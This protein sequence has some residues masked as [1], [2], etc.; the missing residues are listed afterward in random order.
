M[1]IA[2]RNFLTTLRRYKISSLL[3]VAGL[4]L[5][6]TAFYVIMTQVWWEMSYNRSLTDVERIYLVENEDWY[7]PGMWSSWLNRPIPERVVASTAGVEAGGCM[8]GGF[9]SGICWTRNEAS[10]GYNKFSASDGSVSLPLLDVFAFRSVA[11]DVHDLRKPKSVIVSRSAAERNPS[12]TKRW[13]SWPCSRILPAIR[14]WGSAR[15]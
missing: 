6:F 3:N 4:T 2:F 7:E 13:R 14:C 11:G 15:W 10:F 12:P 5:A 8:W 9:G 1:K